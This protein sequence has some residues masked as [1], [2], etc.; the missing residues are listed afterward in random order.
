MQM[1]LK[2]GR[3]TGED[4]RALR[5]NSGG[6][7]L[8][9]NRPSQSAAK[10]PRIPIRNVEEQNAHQDLE[11]GKGLDSLGRLDMNQE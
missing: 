1:R 4:L 10:D 11:S 5:V 8:V 9:V 2:N 7:Q 3:R 6:A